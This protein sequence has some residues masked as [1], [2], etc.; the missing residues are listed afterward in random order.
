MQIDPVYDFGALTMYDPELISDIRELVRMDR[1]T[2]YGKSFH[3]KRT[4]GII[5]L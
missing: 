1:C 4:I 2:L 5:P 3:T